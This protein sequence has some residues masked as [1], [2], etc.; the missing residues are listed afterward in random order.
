MLSLLTDE[1]R[2]QLLSNGAARAR[3]DCLDPYPVVKLYTPD[4]HACWLLSEL[5]P[6]GD[7]AYGLVDLGMGTPD[8]G[9]VRISILAS[10]HGPKD[11]PVRRD[12]YFTAKR[13]LSEYARLAR[14]DGS[15]ND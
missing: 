7:T 15:I 12:L 9:C 4:A 1:E 13:P 3:G 10:I 14:L 11:M 6:D 8:L 5:E 2:T